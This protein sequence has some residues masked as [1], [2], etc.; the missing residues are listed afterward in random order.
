MQTTCPECK[1]T[2]RLSQEQLG[3][4]RG[5]VRCGHCKAVFN[6]YHTL[7]P[8]L[9]SPP[10]HHDVPALPDDT[11]PDLGPSLELPE[12]VPL[13]GMPIQLSQEIAEP[14]AATELAPPEDILLNE[15][16]PGPDKAST[17]IWQGMFYA[18]LS[19]ILSGVLLGQLAYLLRGDLVTRAPSLR[20]YLAALCEPFGCNVPLPRGLDKQA[21]TSSSLEHDVERVT[22]VRL[23]LLLTNRTGYTQAWPYLMLTLTDLHEV[24]VAQKTFPPSVYLPTGLAAAKGMKAGSEREIRLDLDLGKIEASGYSLDLIYL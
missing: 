17:P 20:P 4:R 6:A 21:I 23:T 3:L 22:R 10:L 18:G 14:A 12:D 1:T 24:P 11:E 15:L 16:P 13:A 8:E 5:L 7:M 9:V 19:L 2:F